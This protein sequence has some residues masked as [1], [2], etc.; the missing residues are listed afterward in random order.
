MAAATAADSAFAVPEQTRTEH[1]VIPSCACQRQPHDLQPVLHGFSPFMHPEPHDH[2]TYCW[3]QRQPLMRMQGPTGRPQRLVLESQCIDPTGGQCRIFGGLCCSLG[4]ARCLAGY[5][6]RTLSPWGLRWDRQDQATQG[7][8]CIWPSAG[9]RR[10]RGGVP[11]TGA[12]VNWV[13]GAA[14]WKG[15]AASGAA[16]GEAGG[17]AVWGGDAAEAGPSAA[18]RSPGAADGLSCSR[19]RM[20]LPPAYACHRPG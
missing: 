2:S 3:C 20:R 4:G 5:S 18:G 17:G 9:H 19:W 1:V 14:G 12:P 10:A 8:L 15:G 13:S 16:A 7:W 6:G 11:G